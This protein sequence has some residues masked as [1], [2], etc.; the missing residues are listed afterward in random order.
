[1]NMFIIILK[2]CCRQVFYSFIPVLFSLHYGI[3]S[4]PKYTLSVLGA[5]LLWGIIS[6]FIRQLSAIGFSSLQIMTA[7]AVLSV[8]L[9]AIVL[10]AKDKSL[11]KIDWHDIWMFIGTGIISLASFSI[12]YF[13]TI[14]NCGASVAVVLLYT[15]PVFIIILSALCFREKITWVKAVAVFMT[16]AGCVLVAGIIGIPSTTNSTAAGVHMTEALPVKSFLIG[17]CAGLGYALYSIFG[18]VA[19]KKYNTMT[20]TFYT[21]LFAAVFLVPFS[22]PAQMISLLSTKSIL[23]FLG[24]AF[25]C[26]LVPYLLYTYGLS[27]LETG[28]AAILATI[29]PMVGTVLGIFA[30]GES[31]GIMKIIGIIL[32]IAA[33]CIA[34]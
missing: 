2:I 18:R 16:F 15:S 21:F 10:L 23:L 7:R 14:V 32:I 4:H 17:L 20:I 8:P 11:F 33:I 24:I 31:A 30:Y 34:H 9:A 28:T 5:G 25:V 22:H 26:T 27:G 3:M 1:M 12:C 29:E 13:T 19:L 6:I